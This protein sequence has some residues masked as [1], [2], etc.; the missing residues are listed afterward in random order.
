MAMHGRYRSTPLMR[1]CAGST[2]RT[3]AR[4]RG[5]SRCCSRRLSSRG[6]VG[7]ARMLRAPS[8]RGPTS[9][10][11]WNQPT[12]LFFSRE[13]QPSPKAMC[14]GHGCG[15]RPS[16]GRAPRGSR[17]S[18]T[19]APSTR[20]REFVWTGRDPVRRTCCVDQRRRAQCPN[21]LQQ[22]GRRDRST[23]GRL[24]SLPLDEQFNAV[25]PARQKA[26]M[27]VRS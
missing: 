24:R 6:S 2:E 5:T 15:R 4:A 22:A 23:C 13:Q 19:P 18:R 8:A 20:G 21:R 26:V 11:P 25:P 10:R 17:G 9:I 16:S 27:P 1:L 14:I 3:A 7:F 12:I